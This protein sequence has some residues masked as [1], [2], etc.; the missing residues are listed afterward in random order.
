MY[1]QHSCIH[2]TRLKSNYSWTRLNHDFLWYS[3][4]CL[5]GKQGIITVLT[6]TIFV[7]G[8]WKCDTLMSFS[9]L[10]TTKYPTKYNTKISTTN[11][12]ALSTTTT[13][14][15]CSHPLD[16]WVGIGDSSRPSIPIIIDLIIIVHYS[17]I[18]W[19]RCFQSIFDNIRLIL[20]KSMSFYP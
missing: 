8:L 9:Q 4:L 18:L 17:S 11:Q 5:W 2:P 3:L 16:S 15:S 13:N 7:L 14:V 10:S 12:I 19:P 20:H 6:I 1:T